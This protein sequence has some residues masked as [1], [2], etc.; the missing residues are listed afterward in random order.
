MA[1]HYWRD[2]SQREVDFVVERQENMADT[3]EAKISPD[4]FDAKALRAFR[5]LHP[6]GNNYVVCPTVEDPYPIRRAGFDILVCSTQHLP[7]G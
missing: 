7:E 2:K 5:K 6:N 3:F 1:I 4:A